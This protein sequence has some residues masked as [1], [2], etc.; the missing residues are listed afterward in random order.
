M[1]GVQELPVPTL[2]IGLTNRCSL[3]DDASLR[4]GQFEAQIEVPPLRTTE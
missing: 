4:S 3:M 1:D 2:V